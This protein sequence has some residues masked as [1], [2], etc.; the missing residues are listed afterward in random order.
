MNK[1]ILIFICLIVLCGCNDTQPVTEQDIN[2]IVDPEENAVAVNEP[3]RSLTKSLAEERIRKFLKENSKIYQD[4][5]Q[6]EDIYLV[7]GDYSNNGATD[8]FYTVN[9]YPGGDFIYPTHFLYDSNQDK[10]RELKMN[11]T[12]EFIHSIDVK[13]ITAGKLNGTASIWN[14]LSGEH[15]S[16]RTVKAEFTIEGDKIN[17]D[18][19]FMPAFIKAQKEIQRELQKME[20]EMMEE[21]DAYNSEE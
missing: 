20:R 21:A 6:I 12:I 16:S 4:Y 8:Y 10:I 2:T 19:K 7:G 15:I 17:C 14:A 3:I 1:H 18:K 5:G 9:F 13:E 11:K